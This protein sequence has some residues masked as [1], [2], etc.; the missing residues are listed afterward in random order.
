MGKLICF[1][2]LDGSGK[3]TQEQLLCRRLENEN[4]NFKKIKLPNYDDDACALVKM[5]LQGRFGK[6][7]GDVN[8]FAASA[9]YAVDRYVS[10]NCYWKNEYLAGD[11]I[12]S[13]RYVTSNAYHQLTKLPKEQ[14]DEFLLWLYDFEY[15]KMGIPKPDCVIYLDMPVNVSQKLMTGRYNGNE[16]KKDIHEKNVEYLN[17]CREAADYACKKGNWLKIDCSK[18]GEP[19]SPEEI[20]EKI[21]NMVL[22]V[23][24]GQ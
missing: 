5:Y 18:N 1:E 2:G 10:Y 13:D 8:A 6:N 4:I 11:V 20:S 16:E 22:P 14:W 17:A 23:I 19:L 7:P 9:F 12:V 3:S 24:K 15:N 21:Y